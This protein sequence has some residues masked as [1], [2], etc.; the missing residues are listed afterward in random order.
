MKKLVGNTSI[1]QWD[2]KFKRDVLQH[3]SLFCKP[4]LAVHAAPERV[5]GSAVSVM[6]YNFSPRKAENHKANPSET[7]CCCHSG[8][9]LSPS[10]LCSR[11]TAGCKCPNPCTFPARYLCSDLFLQTL[12]TFRESNAG[13]A[14]SQCIYRWAGLSA[15][16]V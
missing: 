3:C 13:F 4:S 7:R 12:A 10:V 8:R 1:L 5:Q 15:R 14:V 2:W 11:L 6:S 16:V 9:C